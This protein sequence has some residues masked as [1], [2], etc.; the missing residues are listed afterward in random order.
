VS[1][2][3]RPITLDVYSALVDSAT[4]GTAALARIGGQR[5]WDADPAALYRDW[6][7]RNKGLHRE[8]VTPFVPFRELSARAMITVLDD[9]GLSG[10]DAVEVSDAL[11]A[12][13][14]HWP[15]WPDV[16]AGL[17]RL[18]PDHH[19]A[20]LSN[21][22]DDLLATSAPSALVPHHI[23]SEQAR[24][25]KPHPALYDHAR[26]QLGAGWIHVAASG[27]DVR[28]SLEAGLAVVR[29]VRPGHTLDPDGPAPTVEIDDLRDLADAVAAWHDPSAS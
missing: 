23:T 2:R 18:A 9:H 17:A 7:R 22:D 25:Y 11:L 15:L 21:I 10:A 4:G 27:R 12:S 3:P 26:R 20:L 14:R 6:D 29:I 8:V 13:M 19:L 16:V 24:A 1:A 5:G 28:G